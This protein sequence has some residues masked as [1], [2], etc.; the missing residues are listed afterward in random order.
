MREIE[1]GIELSEK[2]FRDGIHYSGEGI[3]LKKGKGSKLLALISEGRISNLC[4]V[5]ILKVKRIVS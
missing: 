5:S 2:A 4:L 1:L 3:V